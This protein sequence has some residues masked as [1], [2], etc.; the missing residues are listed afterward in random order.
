MYI[1]CRNEHVN[2]CKRS[3]LIPI[4][5]PD[6]KLEQGVIM[7]YT[8]FTDNI[9]HSY[10]QKFITTL[11]NLKKTKVDYIVVTHEPDLKEMLIKTQ[12]PF[13]FYHLIDDLMAHHN[14]NAKFYLE[15]A[16][17]LITNPNYRY[18]PTIGTYSNPNTCSAGVLPVVYYKGEILCLLGIDAH[19]FKYSD[20]GG[21]FDFVYTP[22][23]TEPYKST[24]LKSKQIKNGIIDADMLIDHYATF[25]LVKNADLNID[26]NTDYTDCLDNADD[27]GIGQGRK[28]KMYLHP[29]HPSRLKYTHRIGDGDPNTQYTALRELMEETAFIDSNGN[30]QCVFD[31]DVIIDKLY[32][33][34][35]YVYLGGDDKYKYDMY[36]VFFSV[37]ELSNDLQEWFVKAYH[38]YIDDPKKY[39]LDRTSNV[40]YN[41]CYKLPH[42]KEMVG[43]DMIPLN[44]IC[45]AVKNINYK[46]YAIAKKGCEYEHRKAHA[47][48][49]YHSN[50]YQAPILDNM[51]SSFADT[52]IKYNNDFTFITDIALFPKIR[53]LLHLD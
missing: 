25:S 37:D 21:G 51:R 7:M 11:I 3:G 22:H 31:L 30:S 39:V 15:I 52:L 48:A 24:I 34:R 13:M 46:D 5:G 2:I 47:K 53:E 10:M 43:V 17:S 44:Y 36:V 28:S 12:T 32:R 26:M 38:R 20:F 8:D 23:K 41:T 40:A 6:L 14:L 49:H 50:V 19:L 4:Y 16:I 42:N 45:A 9:D 33:Q 27:I 35:S 18:I 29:N 1:V